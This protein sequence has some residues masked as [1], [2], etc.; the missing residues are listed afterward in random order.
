MKKPEKS[1]RPLLLDGKPIDLTRSTPAE[2]KI[3]EFL[4]SSWGVFTQ[5]DLVE[6]FKVGKSCVYDFSVKFPA[7][8]AR[9]AY[10]GY[11]LY[12][13]PKALEEFKK[14]SQLQ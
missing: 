2:A 7:Y 5:K 12:G 4:E 14:L 10:R 9:G 1:R 6:R 11:P 8:C 3:K 13:T